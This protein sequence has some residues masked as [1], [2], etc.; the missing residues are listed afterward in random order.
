[1]AN[2]GA[3][4]AVELLGSMD[5]VSVYA[6]DSQ[7]HQVAPLLNVG[8]SRGDLISR[9]RRIE[10]MGGGIFVY[11]GMKAAWGVLK[12]A[13]LGQ[14]HLSLVSDASDCEEPGDYVAL[15]EEMRAAGTTV[16]VIGLGGRSD[17]DAKLLE[18][19]ASRGGGR[20]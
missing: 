9:I 1:L 14:R 11:E 16:S 5:A 6:V 19:I 13:P 3:A 20:A 15:L 4:R 18:D 10:P 7:A 17:P 2:E 12:N 8:R